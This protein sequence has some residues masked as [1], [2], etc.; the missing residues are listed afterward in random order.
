MSKLRSSISN[1]S[2]L[3]AHLDHRSAWARRF[4]DLISDLGG[5]DAVSPAKKVLVRRAAMMTLQL[6]LLEQRFALNDCGEATKEQI[7]T[8]QRTTNTLR[9]TLETLGLEPQARDVTPHG[10]TLDNLIDNVK[11]QRPSL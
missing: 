7:E 4:A 2:S 8:Y 5:V 3:L 6:E 11:R 9:R 10:V 1:G